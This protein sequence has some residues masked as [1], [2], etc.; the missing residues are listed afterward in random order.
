M[1]VT[2]D[3]YDCLI[4]GSLSFIYIKKKLRGKGFAKK[5]YEIRRDSI[6]CYLNHKTSFPDLILFSN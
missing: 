3:N 4:S 1:G 6:F 5:Y 2:R